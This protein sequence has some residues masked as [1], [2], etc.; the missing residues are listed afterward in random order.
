MNTALR[1][2]Q[3]DLA[4]STAETPSFHLAVADQVDDDAMLGQF[5]PI[6]YHYQMLNQEQRTGP[7][8]EAIGTVVKKGMKVV[9]LG[10]GTGVLSFFAARAG[11]AKVYCVERAPHVAAAAHRFLTANGVADRVVV[12]NTDANLYLPPEPVDVVICEMLHTAMLRE[13]QMSVIASFKKRYLAR[14]GGPLPIF[15]PEAAVLAVQ[16]VDTDFSFH[17]YEA[18]VPMFIDGERAQSRVT[19]RADR[20]LFASFLYG[21]EYSNVLALDVRVTVRQSG[22]INSLRFTHKNLLAIIESEA[23][24]IDWDM[25]ELVLPLTTPI[26]VTAGEEIHVR[27]RYEAGDSLLSLAAA[28]E[29]FPGANPKDGANPTATAAIAPA[30]P[31]ISAIRQKA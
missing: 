30:T 13:K 9:E 5:I 20:S 26:H 7:F 15:L 17:G 14:F 6:H 4:S 22:R 27:F 16:P 11:A 24:S 10:G 19:A 8:E 18:S 3:R 29:A 31:P 23:R 1:L 25:H 2:P 21:D 28:I 12:I